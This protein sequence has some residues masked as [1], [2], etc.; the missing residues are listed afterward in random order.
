[1]RHR[2]AGYSDLRGAL[3]NV[4]ADARRGRDAKVAHDPVDRH[5][6]VR[7]SGCPSLLAGTYGD[8][9]GPVIRSRGLKDCCRHGAAGS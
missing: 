6:A 2:S 7:R 1:M 5:D 9:Q 8:E 3:V 4:A